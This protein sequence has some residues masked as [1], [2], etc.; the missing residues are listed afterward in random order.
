MSDVRTAVQ[1]AQ[2]AARGATGF[3]RVGFTES[4]SF[5]PVV[6]GS[7][8][9]FR[10]EHPEV[11]IALEESPSLKLLL[12]IREGRTDAAFVRPPLPK[13]ADIAFVGLQ[14]EPLVVAVPS[15]H[16]LASRDSID[17]RDL[18]S[19]TFILYP[20]AVRPGIAD[21]IVA[22]CEQAGF[23]PRVGQYAPQLS[24]TINLIAASLGISIV[25]K[26][27]NGMQQRIVSY[28]PLSGAPLTAS[29]GIAHRTAER[30]RTVPNF[31]RV[32]QQVQVQSSM[33]AAG[34][35]HHSPG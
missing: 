25:P 5:N 6:A 34:G 13:S 2:H 20:R 22:A 1:A 8:R 14:D 3:I 24:S 9:R 17:L 27:M 30:A 4:S 26:S 7:L 10:I 23:S 31:V 12:A 33:T 29:L 19:E 15:S 16:P 18:A 32:A 11:Q 28:V 35:R 21:A